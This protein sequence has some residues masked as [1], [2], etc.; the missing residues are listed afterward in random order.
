MFSFLQSTKIRKRQFF[1][2]RQAVVSK[3]K[4]CQSAGFRVP[5]ISFQG[6]G[7]LLSGCRVSISNMAPI[8]PQSPG[9]WPCNRRDYYFIF[10]RF[11]ITRHVT[12]RY[13][14]CKAPLHSMY[15]IVSCHEKVGFM[16]WKEKK[17]TFSLYFAQFALLFWPLRVGRPFFQRV[18][19]S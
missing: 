3:F 5:A 18:D 12:T 14:P 17:S 6:A 2:K 7:H 11:L 1:Q 4:R 10:H 8:S 16:P 13:S 9:L 15:R 19:S